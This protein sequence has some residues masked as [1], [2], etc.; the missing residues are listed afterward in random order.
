MTEMLKTL[1]RLG[2]EEQEAKT[3][4]ALLDLGE[5]TIT[6]LAERAELGRVHMY[7]IAN[8]LIQRGIAAYVVKDNVKYFS[9][10]DPKIL[11]EDIQQKEQELRKI[12]QE[13]RT[14]Q[15]KLTSET[16]VEVYRGRE[17]I[18]SILKMIIKDEKPYYILGGTQE[19]CT[20]FEL[21]NSIFVRRAE[22]LKL[23]GKILAKE[24]D[25]FFKGVNEEYRFVPEH[26]ISSTTQM[27]WGH[28]TAIFIWSEPYH[29]ILIENKEITSSNLTT[30]N[31]L[32]STAK[33]PTKEDVARIKKETTKLKN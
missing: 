17:G 12:L 20:I 29:A 18:N 4:L 8:R 28:K 30:F 16:K 3:Y 2:L 31:Y 26:L 27:L 24:K 6:K 22:E 15:R 21:E 9:A 1:Q 14:R 13:L 19:A 32:W 23:P 5:T 11:L 25:N 10:S 33:K 7:Q